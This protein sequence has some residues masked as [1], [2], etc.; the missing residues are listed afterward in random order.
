MG[1]GGGGDNNN[2]Q[3]FK[4]RVEPRFQRGGFKRR[5]CGD[6]KAVGSN[7]ASKRKTKNKSKWGGGCAPPAPPR[8]RLQTPR[9]YAAK[10]RIETS[11]PSHMKETATRKRCR[12][13]KGEKIRVII[14]ETSSEGESQ[15]YIRGVKRRKTKVYFEKVCK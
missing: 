11:F 8:F 9:S 4:P 13:V 10:K 15:T 3:R 5:L 12:G 6:L 2:P 7:L 14:N 1:G